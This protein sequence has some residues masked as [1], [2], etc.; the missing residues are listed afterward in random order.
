MKE[1]RIAFVND[2]FVPEEQA[3]VSIFDRSFLYGDGLFASMRIHNGRPFRWR[4]HMLRIHRGATVL[5]MSLPLTDGKLRELALELVRLNKTPDAILRLT[6]SRGVGARGYSPKSATT[7]TVAM[8]VHPLT[9]EGNDPPLWR[10]STS[11]MI[12]RS[13]DPLA[14]FK[15]CNRLVQVLARAEADASGCN[16]ALLLNDAGHAVETA[17]GNLFWIK[18]DTVC[19]A[20]LGTG[21]LPGVTRSVVFEV[22]EA[23]GRRVREQNITREQLLHTEGVFASVSSLGVVEVTAIDG[24]PMRRSGFI[25]AIREGY[26]DVVAWETGQQGNGTS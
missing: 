12:L 11:S 26:E 6:I 10:L 2:K 4:R 18:E 7:P 21:I 1:S 9:T 17:S 15:S 22:C 14:H 23:L 16:E 24:T 5:R 20:P 3:V 19:T 8:S 25:S 13:S